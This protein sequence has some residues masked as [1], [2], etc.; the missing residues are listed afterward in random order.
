[1]RTATRT[2]PARRTVASKHPQLA[3]R[4]QSL[5]GTVRARAA[6]QQP[7]PVAG[8]VWPKLG[9]RSR[10]LPFHDEIS[11]VTCAVF[12]PQRR[13]LDVPHILRAISDEEAEKRATAW[14][15][16]QDSH[17]SE[18]TYASAAI[19]MLEYLERRFRSIEPPLTITVL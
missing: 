1:M 3:G 16:I 12:I 8:P 10:L 15:Q 18:W 17:F 2:G 7:R 5:S 13:V 14:A 6:W 19:L 4:G 11:W 9:P